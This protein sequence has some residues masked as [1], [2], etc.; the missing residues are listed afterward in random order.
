MGLVVAAAAALTLYY[1][2]GFAV[3]AVMLLGTAI[4]FSEALA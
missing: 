1:G 3:L 2:E 4:L